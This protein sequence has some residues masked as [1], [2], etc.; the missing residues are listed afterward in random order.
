MN[1]AGHTSSNI[2]FIVPGEYIAIMLNHK[3]VLGFLVI[4]VVFYTVHGIIVEDC[5][6]ERVSYRGNPECKPSTLDTGIKCCDIGNAITVQG[7]LVSR[8]TFENLR[9]IFI[10][11]RRYR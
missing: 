5:Y 6:E 4:T 7:G 2:Y 9:M 10:H 11:V 1:Y 3:A 8:Y